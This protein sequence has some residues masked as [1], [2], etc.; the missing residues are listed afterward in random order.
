[1]LNA[2][3][4]AYSIFAARAHILRGILNGMTYR[5]GDEK[6]YPRGRR[7][8]ENFLEHKRRAKMALLEESGLL[9][10]IEKAVRGRLGPDAGQDIFDAE[11]QRV[12]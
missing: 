12:A 3:S 11:M 1:M 7:T 9:E 6:I 8:I 4:D 5:P 2:D 10:N